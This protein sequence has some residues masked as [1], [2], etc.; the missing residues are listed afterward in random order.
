MFFISFF[1]TLWIYF[2]VIS[3]WT[4]FGEPSSSSSDSP[5]EM[6]SSSTST[7]SISFFLAN[8]LSLSPTFSDLWS[9]ATALVNISAICFCRLFQRRSLFF[10]R[11]FAGRLYLLIAR[12][13]WFLILIFVN[14]WELPLEN[15]KRWK[16]PS[17]LTCSLDQWYHWSG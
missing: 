5:T 15:A 10:R 2:S 17:V 6:I 13:F 16:F 4:P 11:E 14:W 8:Y 9:L 3:C 1:K 12:L 7:T